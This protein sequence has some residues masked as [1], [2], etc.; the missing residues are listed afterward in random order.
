M[1]FV[2]PCQTKLPP[3]QCKRAALRRE[4]L[5]SIYCTLVRPLLEYACPIWHAS[6]Q[7]YLTDNLEA[8]QKRALRIIYPNTS[9]DLAF[10]VSQ[11]PTLADRRKELCRGFYN[12]IRSPNDR[13]KHLL[14]GEVDHGYSL[15]RG[16]KYS[17]PK[18]RTNR[19]A[20]SFIPW[21]TA[22]FQ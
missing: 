21:A 12:T 11:L 6:L 7:Q 8:I 4:E 22:C 20:N 2:A 5:V 19:Y 17:I 13:L 1:K 18:A 15:R 9:Y 3:L 16:R 14:S 10:Q